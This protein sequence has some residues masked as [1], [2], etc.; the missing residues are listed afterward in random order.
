MATLSTP[1]SCLRSVIGT[2]LD[3]FFLELKTSA[4]STTTNTTIT[5][6]IIPAAAISI[7]VVKFVEVVANDG[8]A[9]IVLLIDSAGDMEGSVGIEGVGLVEEVEGSGVGSST[10]GKEGREQRHE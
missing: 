10:A 9:A 2:F 6:M 7:G 4:S 8:E 5:R 3:L 1:S